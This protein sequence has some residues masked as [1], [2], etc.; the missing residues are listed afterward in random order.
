MCRLNVNVYNHSKRL[1]DTNISV[2]T[3]RVSI[4]IYY[5]TDTIKNNVIL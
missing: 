4:F 3:L 5:F 2:C 1:G